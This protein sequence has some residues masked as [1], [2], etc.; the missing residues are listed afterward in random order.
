MGERGDTLSGG[1]RQGV[2]IARAF[3]TQPQIVLLDEP[4][5]AMDHSGEETV[6][7]NIAQAAVDKT[8]IVISHRNAM[9]ELAERLI[10]IDGGQ[11]VADGN[12]EDVTAALRAGKVGKA[13]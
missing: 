10:V 7:R 1:Q 12:K 2:G 11:V 8:M 3:V 9:L 5:S 13:R 4:T 6:K